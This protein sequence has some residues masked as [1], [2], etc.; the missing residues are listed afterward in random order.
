MLAPSAE[1]ATVPPPWL[2]PPWLVNAVQLVQPLVE[3]AP[4][5]VPPPRAV[6]T[7]TIFDVSDL[8]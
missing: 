5:T 4:N 3:T 6:P 2:E 8:A 1:M 7:R